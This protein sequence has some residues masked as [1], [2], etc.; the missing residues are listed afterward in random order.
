MYVCC[1]VYVPYN[2]SSLLYVR[3]R[4]YGLRG[5]KLTPAQQILG[6]K[7]DIRITIQINI[8]WIIFMLRLIVYA[9]IYY[10]IFLVKTL[11]ILYGCRDP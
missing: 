8:E 6:L 9:S 1:Y 5:P 2:V 7:N 10:K 3:I 4:I 11:I